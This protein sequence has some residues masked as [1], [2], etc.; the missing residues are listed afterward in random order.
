MPVTQLTSQLSL[1]RRQIV[2]LARTIAHGSKILILDEPTSALSI[3]EANSLSASSL[4]LSSQVSLSFTSLTGS[5]NSLHL[6]DHFTVLRSGRVVGVAPKAE[7][8]RQWIVESMS[9]PK[10]QVA[11][12]I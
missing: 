7:V 4:N 11:G 3:T 2:E 8:T 6:G 9:R 5:T 12:F 1:G 10:R